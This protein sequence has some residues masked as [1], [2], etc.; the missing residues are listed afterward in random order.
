[1]R[2][3]CD[4]SMWRYSI[5]GIAHVALRCIFIQACGVRINPAQGFTGF[6]AECYMPKTSDTGAPHA[7]I[8]AWYSKKL[9]GL[10]KFA[11]E[12]YVSA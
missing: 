8:T 3:T 4:S 9:Q 5:T 11:V 1:M 2:Y 10:V 6:T 12:R 7:A